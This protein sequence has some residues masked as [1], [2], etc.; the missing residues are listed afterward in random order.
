MR[1]LS[2]TAIAAS[3]IGAALMTASIGSRAASAATRQVTA[4]AGLTWHT[5]KLLND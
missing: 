3:T 2:A 1:S 5:F 4:P